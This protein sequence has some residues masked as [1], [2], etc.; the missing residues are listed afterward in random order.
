MIILTSSEKTKQLSNVVQ[1][2]EEDE[3]EVERT[4]IEVKREIIRDANGE[5][6]GVVVFSIPQLS[7]R[8]TI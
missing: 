2:D 7:M 3:M 4:A 5:Y 1:D 6:L 8:M